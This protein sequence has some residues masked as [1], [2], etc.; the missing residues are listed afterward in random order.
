MESRFNDL[1]D[2]PFG[3]AVDNVRW[4]SFI[5]WTVGLG[6]MVLSQEVDMEDG[7]NLHQW[8]EDQAISYRG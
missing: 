4:Q 1:L 7:V 2:L 8:G 3:F 6:L 5:I